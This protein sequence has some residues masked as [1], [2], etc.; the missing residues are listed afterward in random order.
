MYF[1]ALPYRKSSLSPS[2]STISV[3][4]ILSSSPGDSS[5]VM[6]QGD[7]VLCVTQHPLL[8]AL[9]CRGHFLRSL[10]FVILDRFP[11]ERARRYDP[12]GSL[13]PFEAACHPTN[14]Y[15]YYNCT[16]DIIFYTVQ[17]NMCTSKGKNSEF[18][19]SPSEICLCVCMR[20]EIIRTLWKLSLQFKEELA[21]WQTAV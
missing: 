6:I 4:M 21:A 7:S 10:Q 3:V 19:R 2:S 8:G 15:T 13:L 18:K 1:K 5:P 11:S 14:V 12:E 17:V 20:Q 16:L 9:L